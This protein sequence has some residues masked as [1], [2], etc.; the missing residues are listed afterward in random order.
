M[1]W[2]VVVFP[3]SNDDRDALYA[4]ETVLGYEAEPLWHASDDL[5]G[6]DAVVLPG[7]FSY[8]DYLRAGALA[9]FSPIMRAVVEFAHGG[10]PVL[11]IC[12]GFQILCESGLLPGALVRNC[13]R[14]FLCRPERIRVESTATAFSCALAKGELLSIPVKH[15]EGC[16][17]ASPQ[18]LDSIES[19]GQV[20][21]RYADGAPN[22]AM[23]D[24]AGV[25][26]EARNVVGLMPHPEHA[27]D[28]VLGATDGRSLFASAALW[29][30]EARQRA[31]A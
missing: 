5:K 13:E 10:G 9:R 8:G 14:R 25:A 29:V 27:V 7:G 2:G 6:C 12:N 28:A 21:F 23:N 11:G 20:V 4:L 30:V 3:G 24:I 1:K 26:N 15:G 16:Y 22:G 18:T 19:R 31:R 17:V